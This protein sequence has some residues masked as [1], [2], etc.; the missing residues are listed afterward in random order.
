[1]KFAA[2]NRVDVALSC[3]SVGSHVFKTS[4]EIASEAGPAGGAGPANGNLGGPMVPFPLRTVFTVVWQSTATVIAL[5]LLTY[6]IPT[7][8][9]DLTKVTPDE[10][11]G[12]GINIAGAGQG[13]EFACGAYDHTTVFNYMSVNKV[14]APSPPSP[15]QHTYVCAYVCHVYVHVH[16]HIVFP[17]PSYLVVV[18]CLLFV[19]CCLFLFLFLFP[20]LT[21]T[22]SHTQSPNHPKSLPF[23]VCRYKNLQSVLVHIHFI[24]ISIT[25][26]LS[27]LMMIGTVGI[28][29]VIILT[30]FWVLVSKSVFYFTLFFMLCYPTCVVLCFVLYFQT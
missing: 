1:M 12:L 14:S 28:S 13:C 20:S 5:P 10:T 3:S 9:K 18:C 6:N 24:C 23:T 7:Y 8:L 30:H 19:V 25:C 15:I 29:L 4:P 21:H 27:L 17:M 2:G 11:F 22:H 26:N 16:V